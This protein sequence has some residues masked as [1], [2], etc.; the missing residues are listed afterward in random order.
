MKRK[1]VPVLLISLFC[2]SCSLLE[3]PVETIKNAKL[4]DGKIFD[5][6]L[7]NL[8]PLNWDIPN[9][10]DIFEVPDISHIIDNFD[11]NKVTEEEFDTVKDRIRNCTVTGSLTVSEL[12][13]NINQTISEDFIEEKME[14]NGK[15]HFHSK[16]TETLKV[17]S[18]RADLLVQ[19]GIGEDDS[20]LTDEQLLDLIKQIVPDETLV[21]LEGNLF[22][23]E[24]S[25]T[26]ESYFVY[27]NTVNAYYHCSKNSTGGY[28][29]Y[30]SESE[31]ITIMDEFWELAKGQFQYFTYNKAEKSYV[32]NNMRTST[33]PEEGDDTMNVRIKFYDA[34]PQSIIATYNDTNPDELIVG[35]VNSISFNYSKVGTTSF[36]LPAEIQE[37]L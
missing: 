29:S 5:Y 31:D 33:E 37:L 23:I 19:M 36:T 20:S 8:N 25:N 7:E 32:C 28:Y 27:S 1:I 3:N 14:V 18:S 30:Q 4:F 2:S 24:Q 16:Y 11:H 9:L 15:L 21:S 13:G 35:A 17:L 10:S 26:T 12:S 6:S 22:K 34:I